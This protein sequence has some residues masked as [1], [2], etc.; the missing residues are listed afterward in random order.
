MC[1]TVSRKAG[2]LLASTYQPKRMSPP[3]IDAHKQ[4]ELTTTSKVNPHLN[5]TDVVYIQTKSIRV[6]F[7][8]PRPIHIYPQ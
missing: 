5:E 2:M 8:L 1:C 7:V 4:L 6:M 3:L